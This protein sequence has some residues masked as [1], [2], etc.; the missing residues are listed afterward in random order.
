[1]SDGPWKSLPMRPHWKQVAKQAATGAFS[2][3]ELSRA[4]EA[5]LRKEG[6][7]LRIEAVRRAVGSDDQRV[8]FIPDLSGQLET[9]RAD[10]PGSKFA[11]TFFTCCSTRR[12]EACRDVR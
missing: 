1:M 8:L 6:K 9:L 4:M 3:D 11:E 10:Q 2:A 12:P 7:E 5:A